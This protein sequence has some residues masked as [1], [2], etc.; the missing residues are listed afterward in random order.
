VG[1]ALLEESVAWFREVGFGWGL[2]LA[3]HHLSAVVYAQGDAERAAPL[4]REALE[5]EH[6]LGQKRRIAASLQRIAGLAA[7]QQAEL[8]APPVWR[9]RRLAR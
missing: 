9:R 1:L 3:L 6:R 5:L 7:L 8:P 2:M 4:L